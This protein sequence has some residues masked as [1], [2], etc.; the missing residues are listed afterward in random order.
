[1]PWEEMGEGW[2][3]RILRKTFR[4]GRSILIVQKG[5]VN[6]NWRQVEST[7]VVNKALV[8]YAKWKMFGDNKR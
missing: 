5:F 7:V 1:M 2:D 3:L 8:A 4:S 6:E